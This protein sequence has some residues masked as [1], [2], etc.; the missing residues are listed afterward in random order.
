M[1]T[2]T[3]RLVLLSTL[4]SLAACSRSI[5][6]MALKQVAPRI[7]QFEDMQLS[8]A[9]GET[10]A[11]LLLTGVHSPPKKAITLGLSASA[12]C[13]E[14][15]TWEAE[16]RRRR[17]QFLV[18][19][20][21]QAAI[22][23]KY[24]AD[25]VVAEERA[26]ERAARRHLMIWNR[27]TSIYGVPDDEHT[28]PKLKER[29]Q[30]PY[31]LGLTSGVLAVI[32]DGASGRAVHVSLSI[33]RTVARAAQCVDNQ[34]FWG[35]PNALRASVFRSIPGSAP[36][37]TDPLAML[38]EAASLGD[39]QGIWLPRALHIMSIS[40][41]D[42]DISSLLTTYKQTVNSVT[43]NHDYQLLNVFASFLIRHES[44][45]IWMREVGTRTPKGQLGDIPR[46]DSSVD[47]SALDELLDEEATMNGNSADSTAVKEDLPAEPRPSPSGS[48]TRKPNPTPTPERPKNHE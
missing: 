46:A 33:P 43:S 40:S 42:Q 48:S 28:C 30:L 37:N 2:R 39:S 12:L 13:L 24:A 45:R 26:H 38:E 7:M 18:A 31:L 4:V 3:L 1:L 15:E 34:K 44:D 6:R 25:A 5:D 19:T 11:P 23:G 14:S 16:M 17:A 10:L 32:H 9:V 27:I 8:C 36:P 21:D 22:W 35:L 47:A 29:E 20:S 41:A